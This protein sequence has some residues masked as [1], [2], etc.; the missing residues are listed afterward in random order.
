MKLEV[1]MSFQ[2]FHTIAFKQFC[3]LT[4][5]ARSAESILNQCRP[6]VDSIMC[7]QRGAP[8]PLSPIFPMRT[9]G[10]M[11]IVEKRTTLTPNMKKK[12]L[13]YLIFFSIRRKRRS[14]LGG[15]PNDPP[16]RNLCLFSIL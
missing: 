12:T 5:Q 14:R 7:T 6:N 3:S 10:A 13:V 4:Q 8:F 1:Q 11:V 16:H 9:V 15:S 2:G